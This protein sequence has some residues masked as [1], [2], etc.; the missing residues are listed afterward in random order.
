MID[1]SAVIVGSAEN[2][3]RTQAVKFQSI[4]NPFSI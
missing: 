4:P 1:F 3:R 2:G